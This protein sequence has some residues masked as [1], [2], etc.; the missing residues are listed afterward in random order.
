MAFDGTRS[1]PVGSYIWDYTVAGDTVYALATDGKVQSSRDLVT[2]TQVGT[3]PAVA[4]SI[5]VM[6]GAIYLGG[7]DSAIYKKG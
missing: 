6:N 1:S 7:T 2:W 3:A 4:R 5:G